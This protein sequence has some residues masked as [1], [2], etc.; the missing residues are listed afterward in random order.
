MYHNK[1][2]INLQIRKMFF[3]ICDS[4]KLIFIEYIIFMLSTLLKK[5]SYTYNQQE[6][7]NSINK[8]DSHIESGYEFDISVT[9]VNKYIKQKLLPALR[10]EYQ[11]INKLHGLIKGTIVSLEVIVNIMQVIKKAH[12]F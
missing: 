3:M 11:E 12:L 6:K 7:I 10:G 9:K 5:T 2:L 8:D 4:I 1:L